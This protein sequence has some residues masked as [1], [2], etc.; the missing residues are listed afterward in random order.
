M[1]GHLGITA[2]SIQMERR[3]LPTL[4]KWVELWPSSAKRVEQWAMRH[5]ACPVFPGTADRK[6]PA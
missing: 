5:N 3:F 4:S 6:Q 2:D 1:I